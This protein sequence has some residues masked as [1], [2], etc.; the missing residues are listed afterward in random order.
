MAPSGSLARSVAIATLMAATMLASPLATARADSTTNRAIQ[1]AQAANPAG[2]GATESKGETVEQRITDL[3]T[4][5]KITADEEALWNSVAQA[6][7]EN[8]AIMGKL[9][10]ET[11]TTPPQNMSAVDDLDTYQKFAQTHVDGLTNLIPA[12]GKL[13]AAMPDAQKKIADGVFTPATSAA[14]TSAST[15]PAPA[16]AYYHYYNGGYYRAPPVVYGAPYGGAY[17]GSPYYNGSPYYYPPPVL[18][19]PSIGIS[20]PFIGI[21]IR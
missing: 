5:L 18:Y 9:V 16:R 13:Y 21:G 7:R 12:F 3:H 15:R 19:G 4:A 6:M 11:R 14:S 10:A 1:L 20:L 2:A 8:A 17:Y